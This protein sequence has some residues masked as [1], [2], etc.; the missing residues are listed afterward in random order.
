MS[1]TG[2]QSGS[3]YGTQSSNWQGQKIKVQSVRQVGS[4]CS[5]Q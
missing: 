1:G 4:S 3:S 5:A 2:S